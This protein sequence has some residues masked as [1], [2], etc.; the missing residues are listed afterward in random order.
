MVFKEEKKKDVFAGFGVDTAI[1]E[2]EDHLNRREEEEIRASVSSE[3]VNDS[4]FAGFDENVRKEKERMGKED[5]EKKKKAA[6][7]EA[8]EA[9]GPLRGGGVSSSLRGF[10][11]S[12]RGEVASSL[13]GEG[14][15]SLRG[16]GGLLPS[17][18]RKDGSSSLRGEGTSSLRGLG[19]LFLRSPSARTLSKGSDDND[20]RHPSRRGN[21]EKDSDI[22]MGNEEE[23]ITSKRH[24]S[25]MKKKKKKNKN[26][27]R[28]GTTITASIP[29]EDEEY[30]VDEHEEV[31]SLGDAESDVEEGEISDDDDDDEDDDDDDSFIGPNSPDK[32]RKSSVITRSSTGMPIGGM[33]TSSATGDSSTSAQY[34]DYHWI[35]PH[36]ADTIFSGFDIDSIVKD[37]EKLHR[38]INFG[39]NMGG[40]NNNGLDDIEEEDN[41][42][43]ILGIRVRYRNLANFWLEN[44]PRSHCILFQIVLPFAVIILV[45]FYLGIFL[46]KFEKREEIVANDAIAIG[47]NS[48][49]MNSSDLNGNPYENNLRT[50]FELRTICF[51]H[52]LDKKNSNISNITSVNETIIDL[53][54]IS[55]VS[56][57]VGQDFPNV[58]LGF[59][60]N[61]Q[62]TISEI[63]SYMKICKDA[64]TE[65]LEKFIDFSAKELKA[66][67]QDTMTF[68]WIR[69]WDTSTLGDVNPYFPTDAQLK[70][71]SEQE[72]FYFE[73]WRLDQTKLYEKYS[74][75]C[76]NDSCQ[77][78]AYDNSVIDATGSRMCG[79]NEG[80]SAWF[81]FVVMTTVGYGNVSPV[82]NDGRILVV[83]FGWI[84]IIVW[85][86]L[87]FIAGRVLGILIDDLFRRCNCR[88]MTRNLPSVIVWFSMSMLWIA[89][90]GEHYLHWNNYTDDPDSNANRLVL[91]AFRNGEN[92]TLSQKAEAYWFAYISLLTV[93]KEHCTFEGIFSR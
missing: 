90:V 34:S 77:Q 82:S 2:N 20:R 56:T 63:E 48:Y 31:I 57:L 85:A 29:E 69:C 10:S 37:Y 38:K 68:N 61:P 50:M 43:Q 8:E 81:W 84:T 39:S 62:K 53:D 19:G 79:I 25:Q 5:A 47:R 71:A 14:T 76:T 55:L 4:V 83:V 33:V 41:N 59:D 49:H 89:F 11:Q 88:V 32:R 12:L 80:A 74:E 40:K 70:A 64:G 72:E 60:S 86:I 75:I 52:Y 21:G 65:I 6:K 67:S 36:S 15:S 93:G 42:E 66:A 9:S 26:S 73:S 23:S 16:I 91:T 13:R 78:E 7:E 54:S 51:D 27:S 3:F 1:R 24:R 58:S 17:S 30:D 18:L 35:S 28:S 44:F 22:A 87:L 45:T 92:V 46:A